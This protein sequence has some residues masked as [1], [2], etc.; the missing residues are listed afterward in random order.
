MKWLRSNMLTRY[1]IS[2]DHRWTGRR[3]TYVALKTLAP[4]KC[5]CPGLWRQSLVFFSFQRIRSLSEFFCNFVNKIS[6]VLLHTTN[7]FPCFSNSYCLFLKIKRQWFGWFSNVSHYLAELP[8][9]TAIPWELVHLASALNQPWLEIIF[10]RNNP[11]VTVL[12]EFG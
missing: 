12:K 1:L 8:L 6:S 3:W 10:S 7:L 5:H 9:L 4:I 11:L 2:D